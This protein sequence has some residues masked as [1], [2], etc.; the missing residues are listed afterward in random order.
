MKQNQQLT[1]LAILAIATIAW[2]NPSLAQEGNPITTN[3]YF[4]GQTTIEIE[5]PPPENPFPQMPTGGIC[6]QSLVPAIKGIMGKYPNN[7]GIHIESLQ[8]G[9]VLYSHNADKFFI[10]ASNTKLITTA[11]A[12][13]RLDP[14]SPIG[15]KTLLEWIN[16]TNL[17]SNNYYAN[18]LLRHLGG[19]SAAKTALSKLGINPNDYR[20]ADGS[21]LSRANK[22]KPRTLVQLL[23][24]MYYSPQR[25][26]F[27]ASLPVAGISG[28]L[29]NRLRQTPAQG[30]VHAKTG[31][32]RGVRAL[33]GYIDHPVYG[34][35]VFSILANNS[36]VSG[37]ALVASIDKIVL[38]ASTVTACN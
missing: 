30:V 1:P 24:M 34:T 17:R 35:L 5:V 38:Q 8:D 10:P 19:A 3:D 16:V 36:S 18:T 9:T 32:L 2:A 26:I 13:Q 20:L 11:A 29:R 37:S 12:L 28:T 21:G 4:D 31:T 15:S 33:S 7:W 23:R 22:V 6:S 25:D 14:Q 27:Y